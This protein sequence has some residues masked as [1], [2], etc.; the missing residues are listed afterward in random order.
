VFSGI[1]EGP[2]WEGRIVN[3]VSENDKWAGAERLPK[4][5]VNYSPEGLVRFAGRLAEPLARKSA[6]EN[7]STTGRLHFDRERIPEKT[8]TLL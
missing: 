3:V 7:P 1:G 8:L 6:P 4:N 2:I 5:R